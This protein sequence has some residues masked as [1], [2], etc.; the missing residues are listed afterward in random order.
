MRTLAWS[1]GDRSARHNYFTEMCSG[2]EEGSYLRLM[3]FCITRLGLR[4]KEDRCG[5]W[6]GPLET[7]L[8]LGIRSLVLRV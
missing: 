2:S 6:P 4:V 1:A 3:D 5:H 7:G 8:F